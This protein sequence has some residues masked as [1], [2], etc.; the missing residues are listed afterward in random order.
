MVLIEWKDAYATGIP[1]VD[2]EHRELIGLINKLYEAMSGE[3]ASITVMDFL[4]EIYAHVSAHFALE[5]KIMRERKYDHYK[6]HKAEHEVLLDELRDLMDDYEE[7]AHYNDEAFAT[8]IEHWFTNH[9]K[10]RDARLH[11]HLG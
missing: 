6:E 9:F 7:N 2:L 8:S 4:G 10:T 1:D 11:K 5:E 3:D